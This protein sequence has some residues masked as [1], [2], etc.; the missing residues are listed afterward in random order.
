MNRREF[1]RNCSVGVAALWVG[2]HLPPWVS[3]NKAYAATQDLSLTFTDAIKEMVT[4]NAI[5]PA[6]NYFWILKA[7]TP[8]FDFPAESPGPNIFAFEGDTVN[9]TLT[10]NLDENHRFAVPALETLFPLGGPFAS[11]TLAPGQANVAFSF[12]LPAGSAGTYL[13]YDDLNPPVNRVM[14]LHGAL[15]VMPAAA[16]LVDPL[17]PADPVDPKITP[18]SVPSANVQQLFN[19]L[20][21]AVQFPGLAWQQAGL[22]PAPFP[23]TPGFRQYVWVLHQASPVLFAAVGSAAAGVDFD[24]QTFVD[25]FLNDPLVTQGA[26]KPPVENNTP[27]YFTIV[28]HS[29]HFAHNTPFITPHLRVGEPCLIRVLNAGLWTHSNHIH[30]NHVYVLQV[31]NRFAFQQDVL[32]GQVDNHI[33]ID[34]FNAGPLDTWDWLIPYTRPPDV[35]NARGIGLADAPLP[36]ADPNAVVRQFGIVRQV[37]RDGTVRLRAGNTPPGVTTWPPVQELNMAIPKVGTRA[38][39]VPIHVPLSPMC[40]P[41]HD[42]SE[43]TQTAQG[44]NY[45]QGTIAGINFIGDRNVDPARVLT[46]DNAPLHFDDPDFDAA[47]NERAVFGANVTGP[48]AGPVPPF[49]EEMEG[50]I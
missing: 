48:A 6:Q 29:G 9:L 36:V 1:L 49:E 25:L 45:T 24:A 7:A 39:G 19:D 40:F 15:I 10:N 11:P 43:P 23:T 42:H 32:P 4:H 50:D 31:N 13:Y 33:F 47:A 35:P 27:Q 46:F 44:G 12:T 2:S 21:T 26:N 14:G 28:G 16:A 3:K 17:D 37:R 22:N 20:G 30:A 8:T 34:T 18:Y 5:N 41:M 38:G